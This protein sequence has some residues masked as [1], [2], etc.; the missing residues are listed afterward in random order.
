LLI[1]PRVLA[2]FMFRHFF[3]G[4]AVAGALAEW[5]LACWLLGLAPSTAWHVVVP[6][7][8]AI[9]N[10]RAARRLEVEDATGLLAGRAGHVVLATG[11][12]A[13]LAAGVVVVLAVGWT[14]A[15]LLGAFTA[16]AGMHATAGPEPVL[17]STFRWIATFAVALTGAAVAD[18]YTRGYRR[19]VITS[20]TVPLPGLAAPL[21]IVHL[22]DVHLGLI[23]DRLALR[24]AL[25]R[26]SALDPD[27]VCVTGDLVDSPAVDLESWIP[28]LRHVRARHGV[29]AILGNHD[30]RAAERVADAVTRL[31]DWRL[32]RDEIVTVTVGDARFHL[33]GLEDRLESDP[34]DRLEALLAGLPAGEPAILLAHRPDAFV[35]AAPAVALV[36]AGH[37]HGGQIAVPGLPRLNV[38]RIMQT[39]FDAGTFTRGRS[40]LHVNRGLGTAGQ[41]IR[42]G[43]PREISVLTVVPADQVMSQPPFTASSWPVTKRLRS[44]SKKSTASATSAGVPRNLSAWRSTT[45]RA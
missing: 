45:Q 41:R 30:A 40:V 38:A 42:V 31:T 23:A 13:L 35:T 18:G 29:F 19:L 10:R 6:V 21:R 14:A 16:E 9:V 37:T 32:L 33:V 36:L 27:L 11:F 3:D 20:L 44:E 34:S 22:S 17:G 26:A 12:G 24:E 7:T 2:I 5:S 25:T 43:A 15:G 1:D 8:L 39:R 28:E 4:L